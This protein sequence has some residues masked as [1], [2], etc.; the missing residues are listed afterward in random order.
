MFFRFVFSKWRHLKKILFSPSKYE[1]AESM[2]WCAVLPASSVPQTVL[3][4]GDL[5]SREEGARIAVLL[6]LFRG[7]LEAWKIVL[8]TLCL[9]GLRAT[10]LG[11][12]CFF[13]PS[14]LTLRTEFWDPT[15]CICGGFKFQMCFLSCNMHM[16][17]LE[18]LL[19]YRFCFCRCSLRNYLDAVI[20]S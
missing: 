8:C 12:Y 20:R 13:F 19:K 5:V 1:V 3:H 14:V 16:Y 11:T 4:F 2:F 10:V 7:A 17:H 6:S 15:F 9:L 18:I